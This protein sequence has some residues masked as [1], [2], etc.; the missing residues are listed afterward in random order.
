MELRKKLSYEDLS[1][2]CFE[3]L[4][5]KGLTGVNSRLLS[6]VGRWYH[7]FL[8][9]KVP[10]MTLRVPFYDKKDDLHLL[11]YLSQLDLLYK[12]AGSLPAGGHAGLALFSVRDYRA[13][14]SHY[15]KT[16]TFSWP[17]LRSAGRVLFFE[18][19]IKVSND[20]FLPLFPIEEIHAQ[21]EAINSAFDLFKVIARKNQITFPVTIDPAR[22]ITLL[23]TE[24][25]PLPQRQ[26]LLEQMQT[27]IFKDNA[28][29]RNDLLD[30]LQ[31]KDID[32]TISYKYPYH[33]N[34]PSAVRNEF[35]D[36][37][38]QFTLVMQPRFCYQEIAPQDV[39]LI[40]EEI[41][42]APLD[43]IFELLDSFAIIDDQAPQFMAIALKQFKDD[44]RSAQLNPF[45]APFPIKWFLGI[46]SG[47]PLDHWTGLF[48]KDYLGISPR[49][50]ADALKLVAMFH[51]LDWIAGIPIERNAVAVLPRSQ[52]F[53]EHGHSLRNHLLSKF[54]EV[55]FIDDDLTGF[56]KKA[57]L[58]IFDAFNI[59]FLSNLPL[60]LSHT[61]IKVPVPT[62]AYQIN[63]PFIKF[64]LVNYRYQALFGGAR[65]QLRP[66]NDQHIGLWNEKLK[67]LLKELRK[68][69]R[70]YQRSSGLQ[71]I[72]EKEDI[73]PL[74]E[75]ELAADLSKA[76]MVD[77]V[78]QREAR[79]KYKSVVPELLITK[80]NGR[81]E[82]LR[83]D[84]AVLIKENGY[85]IRTVA[86]MLTAGTVF[87]TVSEVTHQLQ[88]EQIV[89]RL[90]SIS[91]KARRWCEELHQLNLLY[92]DLYDRLCSEGLSIS[93][94]QFEEHYLYSGSMPQDFHLPRSKNDWHIVSR[95]ILIED[96]QNAWM[97]HKCRKDLNSL[98]RAYKAVIELLAKSSS[99]GI[100]VSDD[101]LEQVGQILDEV[102]DLELNAK[103]R[104]HDALSL[105]SEI[106]RKI[107]LTKITEIKEI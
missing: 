105:I 66:I 8:S 73:V 38:K 58:W 104:K 92:N 80:A 65:E 16:G 36:K 86:G 25:L 56:G 102:K 41:T 71:E 87:A 79:L 107:E 70:E 81:I 61:Q 78:L 53:Q 33:S 4:N 17:F 45:I 48:K 106:N 32:R 55:V 100:N 39:Q 89:D 23:I 51:E 10:A 15:K 35:S 90:T 85:L 59:P 5:S 99:F 72:D 54:Q 63:Q 19:G 43:T 28:R 49:L 84:A 62:I 64:L 31:E 47:K 74:I 29:L 12:I 26:L 83:S 67:L 6:I 7:N 50:L 93:P 11:T 68:Q 97:V 13:A 69:S 1:A 20:R 91:D 21:K 3:T 44:W 37:P 14:D 98:K 60:T 57:H 52:M 18:N 77:S 95:H 30:N 46:H 22:S 34:I 27:D 103:D 42:S 9:S 88:A 101:V 2:L 96:A 94:K 82:R 76:E 24:T 75:S 40:P